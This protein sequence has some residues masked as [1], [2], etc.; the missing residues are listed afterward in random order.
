MLAS[1][2]Q[3]RHHSPAAIFS[4][5]LSRSLIQIVAPQAEPTIDAAAHLGRAAARLAGVIG[6]MQRTGTSAARG[7]PL[8]G[9][10]AIDLQ[11]EREEPRI[12]KQ[13]VAHWSSLRV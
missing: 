11:Q 13:G 4:S 5:C 9:K 10:L 6:A 7:L 2:N 12:G 3:R 1:V 8:I